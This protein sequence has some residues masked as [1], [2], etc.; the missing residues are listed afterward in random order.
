MKMWNYRIQER[1][2]WVTG[3]PTTP[4]KP[5]QRCKGEA[6]VWVAS[7]YVTGAKGRVSTTYQ[8]FCQKHGEALVLLRNNPQESEMT[9]TPKKS[10]R[11]NARKTTETAPAAPP[12]VQPRKGRKP[13]E[14]QGKA[15]ENT[16]KITPTVTPTPPTATPTQDPT[17]TEKEQMLTVK[18][19]NCRIVPGSLRVAGGREGFG[20][21][22]TVLI[23]CATCD[24]ERVLATS[25]LQWDTC[26][27][28]V[29]CSKQVKANRKN[30]E[31]VKK[32]L[33]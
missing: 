10:T 23:T 13:K 28:C 16:P 20:H 18:H 22:W 3:L 15:Q 32:S 30:T 21:K 2:S 6:D 4:N 17:V 9:A 31:K 8:P 12:A 26:R 24:K 14:T 25:D 27:Y 29:P 1:T 19:P 5:C 7:D 11:R 33:K